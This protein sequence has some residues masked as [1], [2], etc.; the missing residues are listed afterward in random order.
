MRARGTICAVSGKSAVHYPI[1]SAEVSI[2]NT[3]NTAAS[4][5]VIVGEGTVSHCQR[6]RIQKVNGG[7]ATPANSTSIISGGVVREGAIGYHEGYVRRLNCGAIIGDSAGEAAVQNRQSTLILI[8]R[9]T[10]VTNAS[11]CPV[12]GEDDIIHRQNAAKTENPTAIVSTGIPIGDCQTGDIDS[13][14]IY[15]DR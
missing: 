3:V 6:M 14:R 15:G 1:G 12:V 10:R 9:S 5:C 11:Q 4:G 8:N 7:A 13:D 2:R